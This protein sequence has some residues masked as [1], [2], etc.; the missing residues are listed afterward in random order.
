MAP[1]QAR[2][3]IDRLDEHCD[4][5]ALGSILCEILTGDPAFTGRSSGEI[6]RK[7]S[8]G[9]LKEAFDRLESSGAEMELLSLAKD[10]L[11]PELEDRPRHAGAVT[12]RISTYQAGVQGRLRKAEI[13]RAEEK[14]RTVEAARRARVERDRFRLTIALA[15][16]VLGLISL[17]GGGWVYLDKVRSD[18]HAVTER[19]VS[20]ALDEANLLRGLAKAAPVGDLSRWP[21]AIAAAKKARGLLAAGMIDSGLQRRVED[22][23]VR[24]ENEQAAAIRLAKE[25]ERDRRFLERLEGIRLDRCAHEDPNGGDA[26]RRTDLAYAAAFREF[27]ID[28]ENL[29]PVEADARLKERFAPSEWV[30]FLDDWAMARSRHA[31]QEDVESW[32]KL[33]R[34]AQSIDPD[35]WRVSLRAQ[36]GSTDREPIHR[37]AA[38]AKALSTQ[39][40]IS[41]Y[42]LGRL[43]ET[44]QDD[45]TAVQVLL[46]AWRREPDD[47]AT[48][49]ELGLICRNDRDALRFSTAA[50]AL[51]P[52]NAWSHAALAQAYLPAA[53]LSSCFRFLCVH[54]DGTE[55][56]VR[57]GRQRRHGPSP[58]SPEPGANMGQWAGPSW[59]V[60]PEEIRQADLDLAIKEYREAIRLNPG[61]PDLHNEL[62]EILMHKTGA[63]TEAI[64]EYHTAFRLR[65]A[66]AELRVWAINGLILKGRVDLAEV[67][68]R[69]YLRLNLNRTIFLHW[70]MGTAYHSQG[71]KDLAFQEYRE[72]FMDLGCYPIFVRGFCKATGTPTEFLEIYREAIR[73]NPGD[74]GVL[75]NFAEELI[76]GQR[77][78]EGIAMYLEEINLIRKGIPTQKSSNQD[79]AGAL[80]SLGSF[81]LAYGDIDTAYRNIRE[82]WQIEPGNPD[83]VYRLGRACYARGELKEALVNLREADRL[84]KSSE[85]MIHNDLKRV[86]RMTAMEASLDAILR[87]RSLPTDT[88]SRLDVADL[89]RVTRRVAASAQF[90]RDA[91]LARPALAE[92][93]PA[94]HRLHAAIAAALAGTDTRRASD[95]LPLDDTQGSRW[96][97]QALEWL[98]AERDAY[99]KVVRATPLPVAIPTPPSSGSPEKP[100]SSFDP[101]L[102]TAR[103]ALNVLAHHRNLACVRDED[104]LRKLPES[105]Q[106]EWLAFWTD[107]A[108]LLKKAGEF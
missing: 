85:P 93:R 76:K 7:A 5:F 49:Y 50:V 20:E 78:Q 23:Q 80:N 90:F 55:A 88:E 41:L 53:G 65:P 91:F 29:S 73:R 67:E 44:V 32:R 58:G 59:R 46:E 52:S 56:G 94:R 16:S 84:A 95:D 48:C 101:D 18:R 35:P 100:G 51:R 37:L 47:F 107:V 75:N 36:I 28:I 63:I 4:V 54:D 19:V 57:H 17:G 103:E 3:E 105:E 70:I 12:E 64:E 2:G 83:Y 92:D 38:D 69:E 86:E 62:A 39:P 102:A 24:L 81:L 14:A 71:R 108:A 21:E 97:K 87:G 96:R 26:E 30:S 82:A 68:C 25:R 31:R 6:Q 104:S 40:A 61:D 9:D 8:R 42:L 74:H 89:C 11:A 99:A 10:C 22:L 15:A 45:A 33:V 27:G 13:E 106:K 79:L 60:R 1:E 66:D 34:T 43:L 98:R 77:F 72:A